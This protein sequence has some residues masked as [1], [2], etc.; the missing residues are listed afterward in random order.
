VQSGLH[1]R[2]TNA[3]ERRNLIDGKVAN[4]T[5]FDLSGDD[6]KNRPLALG[7][8]DSKIVG[9]RA[10]STEHSAPVPRCLTV[11]RSLP[12]TWDEAATQST[13][14]FADLLGMQGCVTQRASLV[15]QELKVVSLVVAEFA[16]GIGFPKGPCRL[17]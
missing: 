14:K 7:I 16:G 13:G 12:L 4:A 3:C 6:A 5:P 17:V 1:R 2:P 10:R 8:V 9:Q 11:G 15:D